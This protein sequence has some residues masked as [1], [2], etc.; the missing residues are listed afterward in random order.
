MQPYSTSYPMKLSCSRCRDRKLK[1]DRVEPECKRCQSIGLQCVYP[2]KRKTRGT[3]QKSE[4]HRLDNRLDALEERLKATATPDANNTP[5]TPGPRAEATCPNLELEPGTDK[6]LYQMVSGAKDNIESLTSQSRLASRPESPWAQT[7]VNSAITRLDTAL[8]QLAAPSPRPN[9]N[10]TNESRSSLPVGDV[11][12]YLDTFLDIVLP[13]L[14]LNDIFLGMIDADF[15]RA[16]PI[17]VDSPYA[18][19]DPVMLVIYHC[20]IYL[21]QSIGTNEE[22]RMGLQTYYKCLQ[23]V[24]KWLESATG[25]QLDVLA[26][27]IIAWLAINNFDYHL[28]WQFHCEACRFGDLLGIHQV[29]SLQPGSV[30]EE[31]SKE[32]HRRLHW[33][34]VEVD[35][36]FRLSYDKP[37]ALRASV[38]QVRLPD[39]ISPAK[40][41]PKHYDCVLF[42]VWSRGYYILD[43]FF[44]AI[45][46]LPREEL[47]SK[48]DHYCDQLAELVNDW[49]LFTLARSPKLGIVKSWLYADTII[50]FHTFIICMR[51]KASAVDQPTHQQALQAARVVISTIHEWSQSKISPTGEHKGYNTHLLTFY[52]FCAF[53]TL[54]YHIMASNTPG[55]CEAD[56][57]TLEKVVDIMTEIGSVRRDFVPLANAMG[58][59]NDVSRAV[60]SR[61]EPL[62]NL[63]VVCPAPRAQTNFETIDSSGPPVPPQPGF[64]PIESLQH[65]S[66]NMPLQ[67]TDDLSGAFGVPFELPFDWDTASTNRPDTA[68]TVSQPVDFVRAIES[69]LIWRDWHESWWAQGNT[70]G[71]APAA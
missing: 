62:Q 44:N 56:I 36:H 39:L 46:T 1:C 65:L 12:R 38:F 17:I 51:R 69:E 45:E 66:A 22:Q 28:A 23:S 58:A 31:A 33:F 52:P 35:F 27:S 29:D 6:F 53:F 13:Q 2:E 49:D 7:T 34:L 42:I 3:R 18:Q 21:G 16:M 10:A 40:K 15:L 47:N 26:A 57:C 70:Q 9:G 59:L 4:F 61:Q 60:H 63:T 48:I 68:Q 50:A 14:S 19:L 43:D 25:T 37:K 64:P 54:Y 67:A 30:R 55:E 71:A 8:V 32:Q 5:S 41:Q 11:S 24:P 20:A